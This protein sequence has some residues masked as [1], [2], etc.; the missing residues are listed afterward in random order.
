MTPFPSST[1]W[2]RL[3][4]RK[5][6]AARLLFGF[7]LAFLLPGSVFVFLMQ[8]RLTALEADS[9]EQVAAVRVSEAEMRVEQ[10]VGF[11]AEWVER[12]ARVAEESAWS[13]ATAAALA[14]AGDLAAPAEASRL[15]ADPHGHLW[16]E[17]PEEE[18]VAADLGPRGRRGGGAAPG[19]AHARAGAADGRVAASAA[20]VHDV[21]IWTARGR[22]R[23]S[24]WLDF[25]RANRESGGE[26][27][28]FVFNRVARF[29]AARPAT[30]DEAVWTGVYAGPS[31]TADPRTASVFVPVRNR[32]NASPF[33][34][35]NLLR[36][37]HARSRHSRSASFTSSYPASR[38]NTDCRSKPPNR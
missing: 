7:F 36:S 17:I 27:E 13:L 23:H 1:L 35:P 16:T 5:S 29:P 30:G 12:R 25:H 34:T 4:P 11:R 10:D 14:L 28:R 38:P 19:R 20:G 32:R 24:P 26:L 6:I 33:C 15:P 2:R 37:A 3:D 18:S 31:L 22:M 21:S 9:A 8:R